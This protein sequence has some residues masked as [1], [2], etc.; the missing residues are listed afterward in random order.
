MESR[1][2]KH[3]RDEDVKHNDVSKKR[4][5]SDGVVTISFSCANCQTS[6]SSGTKRSAADDIADAKAR[7]AEMMKKRNP[8]AS[9]STTSSHS[10][11]VEERIAAA[12]ARVAA[13]G[14]VFEQNLQALAKAEED[15]N[16]AR[17]GLSVNVHPSLL[18]ELPTKTDRRNQNVAP[19]FST[20]LAN[21][22]RQTEVVARRIQNREKEEEKE[23]KLE[24]LTKPVESDFSTDNPYYD[25][26]L[27][28]AYSVQKD[29]KTRPIMFNPHGKFIEK[30]KAERT[31]AKMEELKRKIE[32][33]AKKAGLEEDLD[34]GDREVL[35]RPEPPAIEWWD[36]DFFTNKTYDD[37]DTGHII[38]D[39][40][41]TKI[42]LYIQHP[43]PI[44]PP[45]ST[46][47]PP[48]RPVMMTAK[49][50]AKSRRLRRAEDQKDIR[51]K[52]L[53]GLIP[54]E[55]PKIKM[56]NLMKVLTSEAVKDPTAVERRVRREID[57]RKN[58]H[59][60]ENEA[61]KLT[62]EERHVKDSEKREADV[63]RTGLHCCLFRIANLSN[64]S[65]RFKIN[66]TAQQLELTGIVILHPKTN[67]VIVEG[68]L[69]AIK[70]YKRL[71]TVRTN[72]TDNSR[73]TTIRRGNQ[74]IL[75]DQPEPE[76]LSGNTC[77][78]IWEGELKNRNFKIWVGE[79][80]AANDA[81]A[82]KWLGKGA[83]NYWR[84]AVRSGE[85]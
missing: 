42:T 76:D 23:K 70:K 50:M 30:A 8:H 55:P 44:P 66:K 4:K 61:R 71:M 13:R 67:I 60:Q 41:N 73:N 63:L 68:G 51:G 43:I 27:D 19:K 72:W 80:E 40:D 20:T 78:L 16:K 11:A 6:I 31:T 37:I 17:G 85:S 5:S 75:G 53:L 58:K 65:H 81:A 1:R 22:N 79:R 39:G 29:R 48:A 52:T 36:E 32:E 47:A 74:E 24:I 38:L 62:K 77:E 7:I 46:H 49:E 12:N 15:A 69:P 18:A 21:L 56:S 35:L 3:P 57:N 14:Q 33:S 59:E 64:P 84:L 10:K 26:K 82:R 45:S 83:E 25:P 28:A 34:V 9:S 2:S 54:P